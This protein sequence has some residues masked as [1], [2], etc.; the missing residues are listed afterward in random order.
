MRISL[1]VFMI[2][3]IIT[4]LALGGMMT[5]Y[6]FQP[7]VIGERSWM[8][9]C[10]CKDGWEGDACDKCVKDG[11]GCLGTGSKCEDSGDKKGKCTCGDGYAGT[12]CSRIAMGKTDCDDK[13]KLCEEG[14]KC[15]AGKGCFRPCTTVG[16]TSQD[17]ADLS[18]F[19]KCLKVD[20]VGTYC[21][22]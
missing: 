5:Y 22:S 8:R 17:C 18:S 11:K 4:A 3:L 15:F 12:D 16:D 2:A 21:Q 14:T 20:N 10:I 19:K 1:K 13:T 7:C 6:H 9:K